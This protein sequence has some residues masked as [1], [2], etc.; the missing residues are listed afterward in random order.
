MEVGFCEVV[1]NVHLIGSTCVDRNKTNGLTFVKR[2]EGGY[3]YWQETSV[4]H[5]DH[6]H[7]TCYSGIHIICLMPD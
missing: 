4:W 3:G 1:E 7:A 5:A 6:G 2:L